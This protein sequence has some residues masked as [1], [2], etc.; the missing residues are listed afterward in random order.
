MKNDQE[1]AGL[2]TSPLEKQKESRSAE[3]VRGWGFGSER[4]GRKS[5]ACREVLRGTSRS[6]ARLY[7]SQGELSDYA[8]HKSAS[9]QQCNSHARAFLETYSA[10]EPIT[11]GLA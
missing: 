10:D 7:Q 8:I 9:R 2:E 6:V 3:G 11:L 4:P 5:D 1:S